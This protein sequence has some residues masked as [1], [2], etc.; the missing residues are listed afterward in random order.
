MDLYSSLVELGRG[1]LGW[2]FQVYPTGAKKAEDLAL[3]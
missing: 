1:A 3:G 2:L